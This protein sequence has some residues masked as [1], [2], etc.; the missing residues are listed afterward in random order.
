M[1]RSLRPSFSYFSVKNFGNALRGPVIGINFG[2]TNSSVAILENRKAKVLK[3][4]EGSILTPSVVAFTKDDEILVGAP[5]IRQSVL[6][7]QNTIFG[8]KRLIGRKYDE[9]EVLD[10]MR[11]IPYKIV[12]DP[13]GDVLIEVQ[14]K[15]YSPSQITSY[16]LTKLKETAENN[17]NKKVRDAIIT[18][19]SY[20]NNSQKQALEEAGNLAGL[21]VL[22][23]VNESVAA[24]IGYNLD[25]Q[26]GLN[27]IVAVCNLN[28]GIFELELKNY[29]YEVLSNNYDASI[30]G[31]AFDNAIV[32]YFVGEFK[33]ENGIDL[34]QNPVAMQRLHKAAVK[35]KCKL[36]NSTQTEIILPNIIFDSRTFTFS[37]KIVSLQI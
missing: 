33:R 4:D 28:G 23:F 29:F 35:A 31:E 5:A 32:K 15:L 18:V 16:I 14:D 19:P 34:T 17:L 7:S 30:S 3:N 37:N 11:D 9:K 13:N 2:F 25:I 8:I 36:S 10:F 24:A 22:R 12:R 26:I 20:F 1:Y 21:R 6:N 27:E